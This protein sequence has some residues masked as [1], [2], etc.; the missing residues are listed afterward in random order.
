V[1]PDPATSVP[2]SAPAAV[3][4]ARL[5]RPLCTCLAAA[6]LAL[7]AFSATAA[8][9]LADRGDDDAFI[10]LANSLAT[11]EPAQRLDFAWIAVAEMAGEY[12]RILEDSA[13]A[14]P[15]KGS[16]RLKLARWRQATQGFLAELE[17]ALQRTGAVSEI[18]VHVTA[19][20]L[21]TLL[22]GNQPIVI[23][24]PESS[25][26]QLMQQRILDTYCGLYDCRD[27]LYAGPDHES[28]A[29]HPGKGAWILDQTRGGRYTTPDGLVFQF[30]SLAGRAGKEE[31]SEN[32][33]AEL[34]LLV[35]LLREA[36]RGGFAIDWQAL[37]VRPL[38]DSDRAYI[39]LNRAGDYL[40]EPLPHLAGTD[41]LA[42]GGLGWARH[43]VEQ[44]TPAV[45]VIRAD[46]L[47]APNQR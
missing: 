15:H 10:R 24:G 16:S 18:R 17:W 27:I 8:E 26:A 9:V 6:L 22:V 30:S 5:A 38:A 3:F 31:L 43:R 47:A 45:A 33:A 20:R 32:I 39:L 42:N 36:R 35:A 2:G 37:E 14:T 41:V 11:A 40:R 46:R 13:A 1:T 44:D 29:A 4:R 12:R 19:G 7:A 21:V 28:A 23:S 25:D 34:R